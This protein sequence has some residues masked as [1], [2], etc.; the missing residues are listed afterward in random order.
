M[1][2]GNETIDLTDTP[3]L[4]DLKMPLPIWISKY[5]TMPPAQKKVTKVLWVM[6]GSVRPSDENRLARDIL[7]S[8]FNDNLRNF[9]TYVKVVFTFNDKFPMAETAQEWL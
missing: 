6:R 5:N 8:L 9:E 4:F 3:G 7:V 1:R 2:W